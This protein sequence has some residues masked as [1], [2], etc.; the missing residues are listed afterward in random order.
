MHSVSNIQEG[1]GY[2][3]NCCGCCCA[4]LRYVNEQGIESSVA[5]ANYIAAI[6]PEECQGC[7]ECSERCQVQ[8]IEERDGVFTVKE[9]RCIGCGLCV[10]GCPHDAA[11]LRRKP[12]EQILHPPADFSVWE[13]ERLRNRGLPE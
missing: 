12:E 13:K 3:C 8:A 6:D 2:L 4:I 9:D 11:K 1:L 10:T 7:G 5:Q